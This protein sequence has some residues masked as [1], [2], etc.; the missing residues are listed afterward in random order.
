MGVAGAASTALTGAEGS[1]NSR[2]ASGASSAAKAFGAEQIKTTAR[3]RQEA[4]MGTE[5]ANRGWRARKSCS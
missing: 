2:T 1:G 4:R 3:A 5:I